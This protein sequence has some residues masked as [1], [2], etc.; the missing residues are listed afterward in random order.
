MVPQ[1][2][3][4]AQWLEVVECR[5]TGQQRVSSSF[6]RAVVRIKQVV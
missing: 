3:L 6:Y 2:G 4:G 1:D 5:M